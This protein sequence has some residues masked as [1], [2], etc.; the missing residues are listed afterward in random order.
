MSQPIHP[1]QLKTVNNKL[2]ELGKTMVYQP[3]MFRSRPELQQDMIACCKA[4]ASYMTVHM[5]TASIHLATMTPALAEQLH[6]ARNKAKGL[7]EDQ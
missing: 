6:H 3:D 1:G 7:G 2:A 5:L 4:F